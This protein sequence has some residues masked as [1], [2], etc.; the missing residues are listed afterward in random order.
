MSIQRALEELES[1]IDSQ[2]KNGM[3][4]HIRF[5]K[6]EVGYSPDANEWGAFGQTKQDIYETSGITQ[7]P[8][9]GLA[10]K[11][12]CQHPEAKDFTKL[13]KKIVLG[14]QA[15]HDFL[16]DC[17]DPEGEGLACI[18]HPWES[19]LDNSPIFDMPN[20]KAKEILDELGIEQQI[21]KRKDLHKV[22]AAFR[23]G[24]KDYDV[25]G[26][27][28]GYYKRCD[29][30]QKEMAKSSP[31]RV[32]DVLY[33]TLLYKS[34]EAMSDVYVFLNQTC[35]NDCYIGLY[36]KS[37]IRAERI[38]KA[39]HKK[40][41]DEESGEY[42]GYDLQNKTHLKINTIQSLIAH[43]YFCNDKL[44]IQSIINNYQHSQETHFMSTSDKESAY[45]D[46]LKYWRG[47]VW[48]V[49]NWLIIDY[50]KE[51]NPQCAM[52]YAKDT[53][54]LICEGLDEKQTNHNAMQLMHFNLVFE[55]FTTPSK[56]QYK[57]GWLWDSV[58]AAIGWLYVDEKVDTTL[59]KEVMEYKL[60]AIEKGTDLYTIRQEIN[61]KFQVALFD[62][63]YVA[64]TLGE[65][66]IKAPIGSEMMTWTAA[67]YLDLYHY[68][69]Q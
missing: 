61:E 18:V 9:M 54:S 16:L 15:F 32:Q 47:P 46:P 64:Q 58:F 55:R 51:D 33:N 39:I 65:Y 44:K 11:K 35:P 62:E 42:Y 57:H 49:T 6:G 34:V 25:Y 37:K 69:N 50:L 67:V 29:Y 53:V 8:V 12:I 59:F 1:I 63:Y 31:F 4:P 27:L 13:L 17:R 68:I 40:L 5:V 52:K 24:E 20:E 66:Q 2:W 30:D 48:P 19:G 7:P 10:L 14:V 28:M 36:E 38:K 60:Q 3:L 43:I 22:I 56:N 41:Y 21:K 26:K 45:F 23:P